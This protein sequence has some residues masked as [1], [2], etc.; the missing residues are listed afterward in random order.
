MARELDVRDFEES[1]ATDERKAE[2]DR[3]AAL[4][5]S[6][7]PGEHTIRVAK[8]DAT[9]GNS[10]IVASRGAP[11]DSGDFIERALDHVHAISPVLGLAATSPEFVP[12][13]GV[14]EASSGAKAVNLHQHHAGIPVFQ[15]A[16]TVR[17][18]PD[19]A[20]L[21][22]VG[23]T[24]TIASTTALEPAVRVE[25]AVL[26]AARHVAE[27]DPDEGG[28][29]QFGESFDPPRVSI[30]GFEPRVLDSE[31]GPER[32]T[33]LDPGPF[34]EP[35]V[36]SLVWFPLSEQLRLAWSVFTTFPLHVEAWQTL[37]DAQTAEILFCRQRV[38][39]AVATGNVYRVD[40]AGARQSTRF[41]RS[42]VDYGLPFPTATQP[43]WRWCRKCQGLWFAGNPASVCP[44]GGS[45]DQV[46]SGNYMLVGNAPAYPGQQNWRWCRRCGGMFFGGGAA[47]RCPG[48]GAHDPSGSGNYV[49]LN[50]RPLAPGQHGWRWCRTC[51]G[52]FFGLNAGSRCPAGGTHDA[53]GSGDYSLLATP[54]GL[55]NNFPND[56]VATNATTGNSTRAHLEATGPAVTGTTT[57]GGLVFD[58][59]NATGSDQQV[60]N[61]FYYCSYMHDFFYLLGFKEPDGN[62]QQDNFGRGGAQ[63]DPVDARSWPGPVQGT[64]NM[65]TPADG[66]VPI[67]NM[68][69]VS[70]TNRH[71]A[72]DSSVVFHEFMHGV[73]NRLVGGP[74]NVNALDS[75]QSGGMG[76]GWGDYVGCTINGT[77]VVGSWV[78]NRPGGIRGFPYDS[79]FPDDFGDLGTGRYTAVH[80]IGEIWCATLMEM[81]RRA[82]LHLVLQ[83]V[84]DAL[85][86]SPA[87]PSF[88]NMRDAMLTALA[89]MVPGGR[90]SQNQYAGA[91]QAMWMT[92]ARF[93]MGPQAASNGAQ[94]TG[95]VADF[96]VGQDGWRW[97]PK[98]QGLF[99]GGNP[100]SRCP[101]GGSHDATGSGNYDVVNTWATAP[102]QANWRWC[103]KCQG[104]FFG[105]NP[106]SRCPAGGSHDSTGSG[107]YK[108]VFNTVGSSGQYGWRWCRKCQGMFFGGN[109]TSACPAGGAHDRTGSGDYSLMF[110]LR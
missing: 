92:F 13:A 62:F 20:L 80:A 5:S 97:C 35:I 50:Q 42:L 8:V 17:F 70:S 74:A 99:F 15:S 81:N 14:Q 16:T 93:G 73:T 84:V 105:G 55:P 45:H 100:G 60:V 19:G 25:D 29:D 83:V 7:L 66:Q 104:M 39:H 90:L 78:V 67:M 88:L 108:H 48:G 94:L 64:A 11:A 58:P 23:S 51:Q 31:E 4:L 65:W 12:D 69:L 37:V 76:E 109:P 86:L 96:T 47:S 102:G 75:P 71:T 91:W 85:K 9:T 27:P 87:N 53:T 82:D 24:I 77:T 38:Q 57:G 34:E 110:R 41:P 6:E 103:R 106:G 44:A 56:W 32:R 72:F 89:N 61:I 30:E 49:L 52:L 54:S 79:N 40:G 68:G 2:L 26:A 95:I 59:A 98:C 43:N 21:D 36:A 10:A 46:G 107:D 3:L 1:R 101:A 33:V 18:G 63:N 22:A 28:V